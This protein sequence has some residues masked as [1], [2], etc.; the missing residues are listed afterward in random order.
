MLALKQDALAMKEAI[1]RGDLGAYARILS[2]SWIA[3]KQMA[4]GITNPDIDAVFNAAMG[5]GALAGKI[6]GAGGGGFMM[7]F[8][9]ASG[10]MRLLREL[11]RFPGRVMNFHFTG[12]G[13]QS[14]ALLA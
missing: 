10:R 8:V 3:K 12:T 2:R 6:S 4:Q 9:P 14:W 13:A 1:L 11:A 7:F 5:A